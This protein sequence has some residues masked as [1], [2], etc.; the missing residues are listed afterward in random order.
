[1]DKAVGTL[2]SN[3]QA[4]RVNGVSP[5]LLDKITLPAGSLPG[6]SSPVPLCTVAGI[7]VIS[8]TVFMLDLFFEDCRKAIELALTNS[9]LGMTVN[10]GDSGS[11][12]VTVSVSYVVIKI[13]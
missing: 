11:L 10:H 9:G 4:L 7:R 6:S 1:M 12:K 8:P 5:T 13:S 2:V 3:Y